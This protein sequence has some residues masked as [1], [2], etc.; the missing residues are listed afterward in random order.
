M[1]FSEESVEESWRK[2]LANESSSKFILHFNS[3]FIEFVQPCFCFSRM[4][5]AKLGVRATTLSASYM[6]SSSIGS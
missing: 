4:V 1:D 2:E 6:G 5:I 3:S